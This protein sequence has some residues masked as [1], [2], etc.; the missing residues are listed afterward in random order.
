MSSTAIPTFEAND[1][2]S[3]RAGVA[4]P[5]LI[6]NQ[7]GVS[8]GGPIKKNKLFFFYNWEGRKDRSQAANTANVPTTTFKEG[9]VKVLL[10]SGQTVSLNPSD[11]QALDPLGIGENPYIVNLMQQYPS[12]NNPLSGSDKGLNF[13]QLLFNA[14]EPLNNHVQVGKL[15]YNLDNAGH[16]TISIR[17]TLN[18]AS[19]VTGPAVFPGQSPAQVS[20]R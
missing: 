19:S 11:V 18:G 12:G 20:S 5:A 16:D 13:N 1:W 2:F 15:D 3:N 17:G 6:R 14:P 10:K 4:R 9:I 8:L 7:Y